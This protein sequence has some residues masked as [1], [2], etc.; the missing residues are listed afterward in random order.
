LQVF[1]PISLAASPQGDQQGLHGNV[2]QDGFAQTGQVHLVGPMKPGT[3]EG[4]PAEVGAPQVGV[5]QVSLAQVNTPEVQTPQ[6]LT[7][8]VDADEVAIAL[9]VAMLQLLSG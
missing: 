2:R 3:G 7:P 9:A 8:E 5:A 4:S 6:G 1:T